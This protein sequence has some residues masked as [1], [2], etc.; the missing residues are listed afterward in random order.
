[1]SARD[2]ILA[3]VRKALADAP[4]PPEIPR[5]YLTSTGPADLVALFAQRVRDHGATVQ[6]VPDAELPGAVA[7]AL[8][9]RAAAVPPQDGGGTYRLVVPGGLPA[10]W[11]RPGPAWTFVPGDPPPPAAMLDRQDGVITGCVVAIAETGTIVLDHG[12][13]QGHRALTLVPDHHLC[14]VTAERIAGSVPEAVARLDPARPLTWI[15]GPSATSDI[16]LSRV[17]G[18]HGP[19]SLDVIIVGGP[20]APAG[21]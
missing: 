1:M 21:R 15:S 14:V 18:V 20:A 3:R 12:P 16:E 9:A 6:V 13:G 2:R 5:A 11:L 10:Q 7:Q 8:T 17:E 4:E 19:R